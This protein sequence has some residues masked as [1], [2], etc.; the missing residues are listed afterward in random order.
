MGSTE[1][2]TKGELVVEVWQGQGRRGKSLEALGP[3]GL[4]GGIPGCQR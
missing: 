4:R 1:D 2:S 3:S